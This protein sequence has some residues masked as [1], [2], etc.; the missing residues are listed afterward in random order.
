[1][2][3]KLP[4]LAALLVASTAAAA[5]N[6]AG[7]TS[8]PPPSNAGDSGFTELLGMTPLAAVAREGVTIYYTDMTMHWERAGVGTDPEERLDSLIELNAPETFAIPPQ[9]FGNLHADVEG[10]RAEVGFSTFEIDR[11]LAVMRPPHDLYIDVTTVPAD[12]V[13]AAVEAHPL[14]ADR[15]TVVETEHGDYLDWGDGAPTDFTA[16]SPF[17]P[18]GRAGQLGL[19]GDPAT[20]IRTYDPAAVEAALA[21]AAG[22]ADN[23]TE[24]PIVAA[25]AGAL[26]QR[27]VL[28]LAA[29]TKPTSFVPPLT[30][31]PEQIERIL[32]EAVLLLPYFGLAIVQ[33]A[34]EDGGVH[35]EVLL[36]NANEAHATEN[37]ALVE[38]LLAEG[39]DMQTGQPFSELLPGASV[40]VDGPVV[41]VDAPADD[42]FPRLLRMLQSNALFPT[43]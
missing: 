16:R 32:A 43:G 33:S 15:L 13:I 21:A 24:H 42:A 23:A 22:A 27:S 12:T 11:E 36:V 40:A 14:W 3:V 31:T 8:E 34:D 39:V 10:A 20:T 17:R 30:A 5:H 29:V 9:L 25:L 18:L 37:A 6:T 28:Q 35:T 2:H 4:A 1:M 38:E 7:A 19:L 41:R 26:E